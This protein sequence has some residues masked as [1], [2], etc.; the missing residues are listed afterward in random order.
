MK[1][2]T[3]YEPRFIH[4]RIYLHFIFLLSYQPSNS[5]VSPDV[6][7]ALGS[8]TDPKIAIPPKSQSVSGT[9]TMVTDGF[10][11]GLVWF[12]D[13]SLVAVALLCMQEVLLDT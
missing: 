12:Q 8:K 3:G 5:Y 13:T 2:P 7:E 6:T 1:I 4:L 11:A 10:P 9:G